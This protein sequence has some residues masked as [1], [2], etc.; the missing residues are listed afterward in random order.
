MALLSILGLC[1]LLLVSVIELENFYTG[2]T[3]LF[4][5]FST[6]FPPRSVF[7]LLTNNGL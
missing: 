4:E 7:N 5:G 6:D 3:N 1:I 2:L